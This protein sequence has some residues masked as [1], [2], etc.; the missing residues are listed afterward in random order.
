[1]ICIVRSFFVGVLLSWMFMA[2]S[3]VRAEAPTDEVFQEIERQ[4]EQQEAEQ[5][6]AKKHA[7]EEAKRKS[8]EERKILSTDQGSRAGNQ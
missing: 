7:Q 1:M 2:S 6:E 3:T 5:A 8:R 4:I